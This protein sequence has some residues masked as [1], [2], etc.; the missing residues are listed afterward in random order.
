MTQALIIIRYFDKGSHFEKIAMYESKRNIKECNFTNTLE[1]K[2][3]EPLENLS[4]SRP[5]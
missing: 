5:P 2:I 3:M 1:F 4:C